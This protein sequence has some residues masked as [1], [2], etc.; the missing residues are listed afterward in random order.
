MGVLTHH[1]PDPGKNCIERMGYLGSCRCSFLPSLYLN[2]SRLSP[3]LLPPSLSGDV[4]P[5][6]WSHSI[7]Y[8]DGMTE[9][10]TTVNLYIC[11][12]DRHRPDEQFPALISPGCPFVKLELK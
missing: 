1:Q 5:F 9:L 4:K 12:F 3:D 2:L 7:K 11:G 10:R 8:P 6:L